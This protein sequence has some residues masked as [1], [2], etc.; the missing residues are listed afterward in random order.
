MRWPRWRGSLA[1]DRVG[2]PGIASPGDV[3]VVMITLALLIPWFLEH[4]PR[5][6]PPTGRTMPPLLTVPDSAEETGPLTAEGHTLTP[7]NRLFEVSR[8]VGGPVVDVVGP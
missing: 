1:V 4:L 2:Q 6:T 7:G 3:T 8:A 5:P